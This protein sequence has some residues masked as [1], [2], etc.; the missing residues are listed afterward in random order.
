MQRTEIFRL[1][2]TDVF[3][4]VFIYMF[5]VEI[6]DFLATKI[7]FWLSWDLGNRASINTKS[8]FTWF[9]KISY[10]RLCYVGLNGELEI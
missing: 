6:A 3:F 9:Y 2:F 8:I 10:I 5:N 4:C 7:K 1:G